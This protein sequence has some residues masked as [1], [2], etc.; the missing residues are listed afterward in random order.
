M[1]KNKK[2]NNVYFHNFKQKTEQGDEVVDKTFS[3]TTKFSI[4]SNCNTYIFPF[5]FPF[6]LVLQLEM[7]QW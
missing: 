3:K 6:P 4:I 7:K 2:N 1:E 5:G